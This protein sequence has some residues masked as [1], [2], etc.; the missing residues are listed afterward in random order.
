MSLL[1]QQKNQHLMWRA[2]FGP[3]VE[4]LGELSR[5]SPKQF[6][7]AL[8]KASSK[9]PEYINVADDYLQGIY[10]GLE[11]A[12]RQQKKEMDA[13]ERK[14]VQQKNREGIRNLNLFWMYEMVNSAAQL[15]E[16]MALF[17]H[18]HFA[19]RN[20]NVFYQQGLLDV[21]RRNA[22]GNFGTLLKEVSKTAAMLNFLN[23]QQNRKDHPNENFAREVME[24][25]TLG[26]GHYTENDIKEAARAFTGWNANLRGDFVFRKFQHDF[27]SKTVLGKTGDFD[28]EDVLNILLQQKQTA[29]F[30]TQKIYKFF[31][32][33]N[34]DQQK[35]EWLAE[36][37]Y[38]NQ[39]DIARL[40]EDI[41]TS[42]WFFDA[43]NI[44]SRIKS[45]I[46]LL[47]GMQRILP[48]KFEQ[49]EALLLVQ[50]ALG[51]LLFYPPNVAGWPGGKNW[52]DSSTLMLRMRIPQMLN[53]KDEFNVRPKDDDD[54]MMGR[55]EDKNDDPKAK[56]M[57]MVG[58]ANRP[59]QVKI[60]W[61]MYTKHYESI[62]REML[63][64]NI[65]N[66]LF[67]AKSQLNP[68]LIKQYADQTGRENFIK[69][70]TL[71]L[72]STPEYQL[73]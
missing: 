44:G 30:I 45:P 69:T 33:E 49:D 58:R 57:K 66:I 50:R 65:N 60:D 25:F 43:K 64:T 67:Q 23:N 26:R 29:R 48:M 39:Y 5:Y 28:G 36:R 73:C 62:P 54:Q 52:I 14:K 10:K 4:Q 17:W 51:Q 37:F 11:E 6:Y 20:L 24:L 53:E 32:N 56:A 9:K 40:M 72:M 46:E 15:R 34:T 31:V 61:S 41:F 1:N 16:K 21:I 55:K 8:V 2:G 19:C 59:I 35:I 71:Q 27:G 38:N 3:A 7:N 12:G 70:A 22:L 42:D 13:D 18:G 68:E 47:A 63:L